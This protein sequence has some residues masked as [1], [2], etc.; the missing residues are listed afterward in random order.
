MLTNTAVSP[1]LNQG[2]RVL[3]AGFPPAGI[4]LVLDLNLKMSARLNY[5]R[6]TLNFDPKHLVDSWSW[7]Y[8]Q[9]KTL[10]LAV[11]LSEER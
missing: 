10:S 4:N 6:G 1:E 7:A 9:T 3:W 5:H 8:K 2:Y 11:D